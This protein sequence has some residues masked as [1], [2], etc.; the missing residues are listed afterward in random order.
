MRG[1]QAKA[2]KMEEELEAVK[3]D[4]VRLKELVSKERKLR[5]KAQD[6]LRRAR[7]AMEMSGGCRT[8]RLV[9]SRWLELLCFTGLET[10]CLAWEGERWGASPSRGGEARFIGSGAGLVHYGPL[11]RKRVVYVLWGIRA[12]SRCEIGDQREVLVRDVG[13]AAP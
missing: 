8:E 7:Q 4:N 6:S 9:C 13:A 5:E 3:A 10:E 11:S 1:A 2:E 12:F